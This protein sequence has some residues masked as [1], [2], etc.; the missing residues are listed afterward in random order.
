MLFRG[1]LFFEK[2]FPGPFPKN[3]KQIRQAKKVQIGRDKTAVWLTEVLVLQ[4]CT[5]F[6]EYFQMEA[7]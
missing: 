4:I 3:L 6:I 5:F 2:G 1:N 7:F